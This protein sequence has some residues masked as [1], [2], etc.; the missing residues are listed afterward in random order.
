MSQVFDCRNTATR[1][2][3]LFE[4]TVIAI[5]KRI[6]FSIML[7]IK[8]YLT[9][10]SKYDMQAECFKGRILG[11]ILQAIKK[12]KDCCYLLVSSWNLFK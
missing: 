8:T 2:F 12:S 10:T 11:T 7:C 6:L 1:Y 5:E 3:M 9:K 4:G